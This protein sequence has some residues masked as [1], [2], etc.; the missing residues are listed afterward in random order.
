MCGLVGIGGAWLRFARLIKLVG[1]LWDLFGLYLRA[2][3]Q[4]QHS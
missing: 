1:A 3:S 4:R 2:N